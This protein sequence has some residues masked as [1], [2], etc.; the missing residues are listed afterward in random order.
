M[1]KIAE[2]I[3]DGSAHR[4]KDNSTADF[5][6][7]HEDQQNMMSTFYHIS[8]GPAVCMFRDCKSVYLMTI[9]TYKHTHPLLR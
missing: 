1:D 6:R 5:I 7:C 3:S 2:F 4:F 8:T 9:L